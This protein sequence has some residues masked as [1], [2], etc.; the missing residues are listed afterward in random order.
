MLH[1][2]ISYFTGDINKDKRSDIRCMACGESLKGKKANGPLSYVMA[3]SGNKKEHWSY[4]CPH[5]ELE[6][7][8][9]LVALLQEMEKLASEKLKAIVRDEYDDK[10]M[11]FIKKHFKK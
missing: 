1:S 7:H 5:S 6:D 8:A 3:V 2:G 11:D 4:T 10:R 9:V